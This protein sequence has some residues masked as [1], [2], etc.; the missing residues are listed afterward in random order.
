VLVTKVREVRLPSPVVPFTVP[1]ASDPVQVTVVIMLLLALLAT[2]VAAVL[3]VR[4]ALI[5]PL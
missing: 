1:A 3:G 4:L 5:S 2:S